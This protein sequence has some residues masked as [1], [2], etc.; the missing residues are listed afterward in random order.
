[1]AISVEERNTMEKEIISFIDNN[2]ERYLKANAISSLGDCKYGGKLSKELFYNILY[3]ESNASIEKEKE[4]D[5]W[6]SRRNN[7]AII[8]GYVGCGKTTFTHHYL[9]RESDLNN[10][11][12]LFD[13]EKINRIP[14]RNIVIDKFELHLYQLMR[15]KNSEF[16]KVLKKLYSQN[17]AIFDLFDSNNNLVKFIDIYL[18][19]SLN[20]KKYLQNSD[21]KKS[22]LSL[23]I[24]D[25]FNILFLY[26]FA[27]KIITGFNQTHIICFD[28]L[29]VAYEGSNLEEFYLA[30]MNTLA[31]WEDVIAK[32]KISDRGDNTIDLYRDIKFIFC[33]RETSKSKLT[34]FFRR[35]I[36]TSVKP[37]D[38]TEIYDKAKIIEK[39]IQLLLKYREDVDPEIIAEAEVIQKIIED[40]YNK[41]NVFPLFNHDYRSC[42]ESITALCENKKSLMSYIKLSNMALA[43]NLLKYAKYG[44]RG[45]LFR[46]IFNEFRKE[47][48]YDKISIYDFNNSG[49]NEQFSIPRMILTYVSN[50]QTNKGRVKPGIG[51]DN[52]PVSINRIFDAFKGIIQPE[53]ITNCIIN[54]YELRESS[55]NHLITFDTL[56]GTDVECL[57]NEL[58][59]YKQN[60]DIEYSKVLITCS[61]T[62]Y[63]NIMTTHFEFF[64]SRLWGGEKSPLFAV[65]NAVRENE[66]FAFE[67][68]LDKVYTNVKGCCMRI[69]KFDTD[70]LLPKYENMDNKYAE[71][72]DSEY[73]YK[74]R[75]I[76]EN[77]IVKQ[78]HGEKIIHTHISY[79]DAYRLFLLNTN[80]LNNDEVRKAASKTIIEYIEKYI[81]LIEDRKVI[82]SDASLGI[83][84]SYSKAIKKIRGSEYSDFTTEISVA[85]G[86]LL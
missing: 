84:E 48:D 20:R 6:F 62:T 57:R 72:L 55:W 44:A 10:K 42:V 34:K 63:L 77:K 12:I 15:D 7:I 17:R 51:D 8:T 52:T 54:M 59:A 37:F 9:K 41:I 73:V 47:G 82:Y 74:E 69:K 70:Y 56:L 30:F 58:K 27:D 32:L 38:I 14:A 13:F 2:L 16:R 80:I 36:S 33:M 28:N 40:Y 3:D 4:I 26:I 31:N 64:C 18:Q 35:R 25:L 39:R 83:V 79:L 21:L 43:P 76:I 50:V 61:G 68:I 75:K 45:I 85:S 60:K 78:F 49:H 5:K 24:D 81:S 67:D 66:E 23:N 29:D 53:V 22:L 65:E 1:M 86:Q 71:Y 11:V 46:L 19:Q